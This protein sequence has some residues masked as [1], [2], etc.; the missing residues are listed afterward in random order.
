MDRQPV[1]EVLPLGQLDHLP[2]VDAR[3][4]AGLRLLVKRILHGPGLE[5]LLW[6]KCFLFVKYFTE[7]GQIH[8]DYIAIM[9]FLKSKHSMY[10]YHNDRSVLVS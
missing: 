6:S 10:K 7:F 5:L 1:V 9:P 3:V 8:L 2:Q 4:E